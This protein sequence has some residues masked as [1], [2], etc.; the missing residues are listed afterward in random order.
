MKKSLKKT[1]SSLVGQRRLILFTAVRNFYVDFKLFCKYSTVFK[2]DSLNKMEAKII[3]DYHS[4]EKGMLF[5]EMKPSFAKIRVQRLHNLLSDANIADKVNRSQIKVAYQ[6]MC[7]YYELHAKSNFDISDFYTAEQYDRYKALLKEDYY[8]DFNGVIQYNKE[9]FY[10]NNKLSFQKFAY[11]RKS[12]RDYT[13]EKVPTSIISKAIELALTSPSVCNRQASKVY[14]LED[15]DKIIRALKIQGGFSGYMDNVSQLLILTNDR[16]YYYTIGE[17]N[18]LYIDGGI[19]LMN[20]LYALHYYEVANCPANWGKEFFAEE[21]LSKVVS[22]PESEKIICMIPI[23]VAKDKFR[24]TL[25]K[26]R[27]SDEV[28]HFLR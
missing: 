18:Q 5:T 25:S 4:L 27:E 22:I 17:R 7:Q 2:L 13:G 20:L 6:V 28:L 10:K 21:M 23:G 8:V 14:L 24:V 9:D 1:L 11:S 3:L 26:R 12:I 15:K 16:S 19:F